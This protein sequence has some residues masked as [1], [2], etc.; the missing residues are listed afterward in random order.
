MERS[1]EL[2]SSPLITVVVPVYNAEDYLDRCMRSLQRQT[3]PNLEILLIN[4]G[5]VDDSAIICDGLEEEYDNVTVYHEKENLGV[6]HSRNLGIDK[7]KGEYITFVDADDWLEDDMIE[8]LCQ[9]LQTDKTDMVGCGFVIRDSVEQKQKIPTSIENEVAAPIVNVKSTILSSKDFLENRIFYGDSRCWSKL[10]RTDILKEKV[11]YPEDLTIG[12]DTLFLVNY[13]KQVDKVSI[14][15][16]YKGY[17]Y[18]LNSQGAMLK[19]F[20]PSAMDQ[21]TCWERI[22]KTMGVNHTRFHWTML[23]S[24][25]LV[26]GRI[27]ILSKE[28][29]T[30]YS[31]ELKVCSQKMEQYYTKEAFQML[32][33]G[34]KLKVSIYRKSPALYLKLYQ[35]WKH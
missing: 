26:V 32:D 1:K 13:L 12:E 30:K 25:M 31:S 4:G 10:Y 18:Y 33:K 17:C 28:E 20:K 6:S 16:D 24:V 9:T 5:S 27:A 21:I 14:I 3:Y 34:Y 19:P 15:E 11:R 2:N 7:A 29:Q 23:V 8:T 35:L 22:A